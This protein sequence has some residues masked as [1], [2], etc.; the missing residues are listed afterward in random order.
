MRA[1]FDRTLNPPDAAYQRYR[2]TLLAE[3]CKTFS[4]LHNSTSRAQRHK[5]MDKL[6]D[7]EALALTLASERR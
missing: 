1:L 5:A 3:N 6:K 2:D 7:Y 4:D